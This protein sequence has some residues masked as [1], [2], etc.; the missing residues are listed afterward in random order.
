MKELLYI[1]LL[2]LLLYVLYVEKSVTNL[3]I[4]SVSLLVL[5]IYVYKY[6]YTYQENFSIT[7]ENMYNDDSYIESIPDYIKNSLIYYISSF[8][9]RYIEFDK[10]SLKNQ[11]NSEIGALLTQSLQSFPY[12]YYNQYD[13]IKITS[14][15]DCANA[16]TT[17]ESFDKF[18]VFLYM[19]IN[20]SK[21]SFNDVSYSLLQFDHSN[22]EGKLNSKLLD[23]QFKFVSGHLNPS[24]EIFIANNKLPVSYTYSIDDYYD[25]KIFADNKYHLFTF[26]KDSGKVYFY[27]DNHLMINCNDESCFNISS[28][29]L[30][31]DDI[32]I[33]IRDSLIR[34]NDNVS[35]GLNLNIN[36]FGIYRHKVLSSDDVKKINDYYRDIKLNLSTSYL[37]LK[38]TNNR[39]Q[40]ALD[41]YTKL[42]PL[43]NETI[44]SSRECSG[45]NDWNNVNE[46]LANTE[47]FK[48]V[49]NYCNGLNTYENDKVCSFMK[50][51]NIFKMASALDSNLFM[52]NPSNQGNM[53]ETIHNKI[54]SKLDQL[55]L[56][57]IYLDKS[58]R[59]N[60]GK[61]SGE[62][63]RLINDL[64]QTNQ[65]VDINTLESLYSNQVNTQIT[66]DIEYNNL[67]N[68]L[69]FSNDN[70]YINMY[71]S[72]LAQETTSSSSIENVNLNNSNNDNTEQLHDDLIDLTYDDIGKPD[73]Y[74]HILNRHKQDKIEKEIGS[75]WNLLNWWF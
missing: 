41:G 63:E 21:S 50:R 37:A 70:S 47:C 69:S 33:K 42:C 3:V 73:A 64:L 52:Y 27:I 16:K 23:I 2:L 43:S 54:L 14:K 12:D 1:A 68:N 35:G 9:K 11:I 4:I 19:K 56:K 31:R 29:T 67:Y 48:K 6:K 49:V 55:G 72:L 17:L 59:D 10:N 62:M 32:E 74:N 60:K 5:L 20:T 51:D 75:S 25:Q 30:F 28:L 53:D 38:Q 8:D 40:S 15:V 24:I 58:Y 34:L 65:T 36:A 39:I 61:Y 26:I 45:I 22:I 46:I 71:N 18:S 66:D 13:G 7:H 44:C 57:N